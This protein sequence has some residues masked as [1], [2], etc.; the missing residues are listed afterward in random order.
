MA[1][2]GVE[3]I[4]IALNISQRRVLG[5]PKTK[6]GRY[7]LVPCLEWYVRFLQRRPACCTLRYKRLSVKT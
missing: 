6:R 3:Q 5:M 2:V 4:A 1:T 7:D